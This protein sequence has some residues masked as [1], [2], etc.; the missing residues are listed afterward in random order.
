M[1]RLHTTDSL[2]HDPHLEAVGFFRPV[3]HPTEGALCTP[4]PVGRYSRTPPSLHRH[5]PCIGEHSAELL[6]EAGYGEADVADLIARGIAREAA[7]SP[8]SAN[9]PEITP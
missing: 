7:A 5:A 1:A 4:A 3:D 6:R 8:S 2:L 9:T